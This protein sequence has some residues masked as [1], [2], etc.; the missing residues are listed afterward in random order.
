[1]ILIVISGTLLFFT[2]L[3]YLNIIKYNRT[4]YISQAIQFCFIVYRAYFYGSA[5]LWSSFQLLNANFKKN[6]SMQLICY[7]LSLLIF[8]LVYSLQYDGFLKLSMGSEIFQ[9]CC[10][11]LYFFY[12]NKNNNENLKLIEDK[13]LSEIKKYCFLKIFNKNKKLVITYP[14]TDESKKF[15]FFPNNNQ[16]ICLFRVY[17]D[18][19]ISSSPSN[20]KSFNRTKIFNNTEDFLSYLES[21]DNLDNLGFNWYSAT[22]LDQ[23]TKIKTK[24]RVT[25]SKLKN[26][27]IVLFFMKIDPTLE[28]KSFGKFLHLKKDISNIFTH[29]LKTPLN[30]VLGHLTQAYYDQE[31]DVQIQNNYIKPAYINSKLQLFQVQDLIEYLNFDQDNYTLQICK[32]NLKTLLYSLQELIQQQC[33]M[34][35]IHLLFT[36]NEMRY[37]KLD[38]VFIYS[39]VLKLERILFNLLNLTYRNTTENGCISLNIVIDKDLDEASFS[40]S[41]TGLE[42]SQGEIDEI[43]YLIFCQ[44]QFKPIKKKPH[45]YQEMI[46]TLSLTNKLIKSVNQFT[47]YSLEL[48]QTKNTGI[49]Y[50]FKININRDRSAENSQEQ[51]KIGY[52]LKQRSLKQL[53]TH[54][55]ISQKSIFSGQE[56]S[57]PILEDSIDEPFAKTP[58]VV[59]MSMPSQRKWLQKKKEDQIQLLSQT[60]F[61]QANSILIVDDEPFNHDTLILMLKTLGFNSY[62][63]AFDGQQAINL[64]FAKQNEIY[65]VFMDLDMPI[66]GGIE[67]T[68]FLVQEMI[69]CNLP[70]FPIIG[71]TAHGDAESIEQCKQAGMLHVVV[72]PVFIKTLKETFHLISDDSIKKSYNRVGSL[73]FS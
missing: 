37:V 5:Q 68:K 48:C 25:Q 72:K 41:D 16:F 44:N 24:Y 52:I 29:K 50:K 8:V 19:E 47:N 34:K 9:C 59:K 27:T 66:M 54:H 67:A 40:I 28:K 70:Y 58:L 23:Q 63:K 46:I 22:I 20:Q 64:A 55:Q 14:K 18:Q 42:L 38:N 1:M 35:S 6:Y 17:M 10:Y 13:L 32:I 39:D 45:Y 2:L 57:V 71:C 65:V 30:A 73:Q 36:I 7:F 69:K 12:Q 11:M 62:L 60:Q 31:V 15:D 43:N 33:Q 26:D 4:F 56:Q 53:H 61:H 51:Y 3:I 49:V 21:A